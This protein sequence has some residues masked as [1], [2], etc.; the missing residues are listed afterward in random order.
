MMQ[1]PTIADEIARLELEA[2]R[3]DW[4]SRRPRACP[5]SAW[6]AEE[7]YRV[8]LVKIADLRVKLQAANEA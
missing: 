8:T 3:L 4:E 6:D 7:K 2:R 1:E 5:R